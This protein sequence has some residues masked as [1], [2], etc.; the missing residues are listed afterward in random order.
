[1]GSCLFAP[2]EPGAVLRALA[3]ESTRVVT[4]TIT[5]DGYHVDPGSGEL[6]VDH[7]AVARDLRL[8]HRPATAVGYL[9]EALDRRRRAGLDPFTVLSC[10]NV[11]GNGRVARSA[12]TGFAR[13]RDP[14]LAAWIEERVAF[15]H[16]IVDRITPATTPA[17][18][19]ALAEEFGVDDRWPVT[20][21]PFSQWVVE[22]EFCNRRPPL[23]EVGVQFVADVG[24]YELTKKRLLNGSHSAMAYLGHLAGHRDS[25]AVVADPV[26]AAYLTRLMDQEIAPLLPG[27]AAGDPL[28]YAR[29]VRRRLAN[30][31]MG[32]RLARLG[33]RGST[34]LPAYLLPSVA[35]ARAAGRPHPLLTLAVAGWMRYLRGVDD[36]GRPIDVEDAR[37]KRLCALALRGGIDP[38]PLLRERDIFGDL[39]GDE[40]FAEELSDALRT[41]SRAGARGAVAA[42]VEPALGMP[43]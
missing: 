11:P 21:E 9:V 7:P 33:A 15:P 29:T 36:H 31:R 10:D 23:Q 42:A 16:T 35:E 39:S 5:G 8:P 25:A 6:I 28:E 4:L 1:M 43:A 30:P 19:S 22:D 32:D 3:A 2:D 20:T 38:R 13:L 12:V 17:A 37:A 27:D 40:R 34:K 41:L 24:P 26:F 18:R 14:R